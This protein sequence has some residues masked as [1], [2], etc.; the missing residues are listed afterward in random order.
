M[1]FKSK[2]P[3]LREAPRKVDPLGQG[4]RAA[5]IAWCPK[6]KTKRYVSG[7]TCLHCGG[8]A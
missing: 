1:A 5:V 8:K 6:C 4:T 7:G 2:A 3:K